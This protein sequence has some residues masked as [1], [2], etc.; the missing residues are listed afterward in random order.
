MLGASRFRRGFAALLFFTKKR[1]V[2][3]C[4]YLYTVSHGHIQVC[5]SNE[6]KILVSQDKKNSNDN[7]NA[8]LFLTMLWTLSLMRAEVYTVEAFVSCGQR[9]C[10]RRV[11]TE[12]MRC[13]IPP[14]LQ[15]CFDRRKISPLWLNFGMMFDVFF[16]DVWTCLKTCF[17]KCLKP[18]SELEPS[19]IRIQNM[20]Q[21]LSF[22]RNR[23]GMF[24][25]LQVMDFW[26]FYRHAPRRLCN[27]Q[28][29]TATD[30]WAAVCFEIYIA[31]RGVLSAWLLGPGFTIPFHWLARWP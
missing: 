22:H 11:H 24:F 17:G 31:L 16:P 13:S 4:W 2:N 9:S 5:R 8:A 21:G 23:G 29:P 14:Y 3:V 15:R 1:N 6:N 27:V 28:R 25:L 19:L 12:P 30:N 7:V 10:G 26:C 20:D 18:L